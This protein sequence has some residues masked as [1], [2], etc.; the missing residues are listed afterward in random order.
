MNFDQ[1]HVKS[2]IRH[3]LIAMRVAK[4][5]YFSTLIASADNHPADLFPITQSY[6]VRRAPPRTSEAFIFRLFWL[7]IR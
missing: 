6:W 1:P 5:Q 7:A 3:Y 2:H 4:C